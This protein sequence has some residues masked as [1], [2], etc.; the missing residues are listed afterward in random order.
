MQIVEEVTSRATNFGK[1]NC[2]V[3]QMIA[4]WIFMLAISRRE[5]VNGM[6]EAVK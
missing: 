4:I 1:R 6:G 2:N 5:P 3:F